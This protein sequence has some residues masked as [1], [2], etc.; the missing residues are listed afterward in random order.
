MFLIPEFK[1]DVNCSTIVGSGTDSKYSLMRL[2]AKEMVKDLR[3]S[4]GLV[5][6]MELAIRRRS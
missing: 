2:A 4:S 6:G 3:D 1:A 5:L